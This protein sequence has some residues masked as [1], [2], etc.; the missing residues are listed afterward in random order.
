M[1]VFGL[2]IVLAWL[3]PNICQ[4]QAT[5]QQA[6]NATEV[7]GRWLSRSTGHYDFLP[8]TPIG[9]KR[10]GVKFFIVGD[11]T[12]FLERMGIQD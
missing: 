12:Y 9:P 8:A 7:I 5:L 1:H 10:A 2:F 4:A 3:I 11:K 6:Q